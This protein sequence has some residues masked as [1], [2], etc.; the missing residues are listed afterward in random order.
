MRRHPATRILPA[1]NT[2][3]RPAAPYYGNLTTAPFPGYFTFNGYVKHDLQTG[4]SWEVRLPEGQFASEAPFAPRVNAV[5]EDDGYL[6]TFIMN[7]NTQ[8][9]EVALIDC[10]NFAAGPICRVELPHQIASGTHACWANGSDL[11]SGP[12]AYPTAPRAA[13]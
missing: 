11:R 12:L 2:G 6:V 3:L 10:K 7:E 9:S 8:R 13:A 1:T 4:Q 5:D